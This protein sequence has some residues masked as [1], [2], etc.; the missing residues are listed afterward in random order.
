MAAAQDLRASGRLPLEDSPKNPDCEGKMSGGTSPGASPVV[1]SFPSVDFKVFYKGI[2]QRAG[3]GRP[4]PK[5]DEDYPE[6]IM[7]SPEPG[8]PHDNM[9]EKK[10]EWEE[11]DTEAMRMGLARTQPRRKAAKTDLL[12]LAQQNE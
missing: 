10:P 5:E 1:A 11:T 9:E 6:I 7:L 12:Q 8:Q 4:E 2:L 3:K